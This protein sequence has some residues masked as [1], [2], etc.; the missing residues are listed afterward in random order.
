MCKNKT[1]NLFSDEMAL[2]LNKSRK[3]NYMKKIVI[4]FIGVLISGSTIAQAEKSA[5]ERAKNQTE[6]ISQEA[7][8]TNEQKS[9]VYEINLGINQKND[10]LKTSTLSE[11][12]QKKIQNQNNEVRRQ[13]ISALL[14]PEQKD[15]MKKKMSK[16]KEIRKK[17]MRGKA[18]RQIQEK[19]SL[20]H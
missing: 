2:Y 16:K 5:T 20:N 19:N 13:M 6:R 15:I 7:N 17:K 18:K 4:L 14:T 3:I 12:E 8:L 9:K 1:D 10:A 11:E